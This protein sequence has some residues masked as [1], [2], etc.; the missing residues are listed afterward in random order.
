M[1]LLHFVGGFSAH[2]G[3]ELS[4]LELISMDLAHQ[5]YPEAE[6][7]AWTLK[8]S[9][10]NLPD[11]C[12]KQIV[13][14]S[15]LTNWPN[16]TIK[17]GEHMSD[18]IRLYALLLHG[19]LYIDTDVLCMRRLQEQYLDKICFAKQ[20]RNNKSQLINNGIIYSPEPGHRLLYAYLANYLNAKSMGQWEK[21]SCRG[22][23]KAYLAYS[24]DC[25]LFKYYE[26]HGT[27]WPCK[28]LTE[29]PKRIDKAYFWH[30][31]GKPKELNS[32]LILDYIQTELCLDIA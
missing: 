23:Y 21:L 30:L 22:L 29:L 12:K 14:E 27:G 6:I 13:P 32:K 28:E 20:S 17:Y 7:Y 8:E 19:G 10:S 26:F 2:K 5:V 24:D 3:K 4:A 11:Y 31:I 15:V 25:N 9:W 1:K 18:K 16:Y